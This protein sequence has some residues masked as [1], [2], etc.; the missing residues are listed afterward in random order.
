MIEIVRGANQSLR[1]SSLG[2]KFFDHIFARS[3]PQD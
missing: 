1:R 2:E 3:Q